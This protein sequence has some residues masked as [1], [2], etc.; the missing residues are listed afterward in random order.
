MKV[1]FLTRLFYPHVGGIEKHIEKVSEVLQSK[2]CEV[3]V[4][5]IKYDKSLPDN[6]DYKNIKIRRFRQPAIKF[7]GT[8]YTWIFLFRKRSL[9]EESDVVHIH[10]VFVWYWPFKLIYPNKKVYIT[11]HGRWGAYPI[12]YKDII[13]KRLGAKLSDGVI[14][15]G[16]Y[17]TKNYSINAD[18]ISYGATEVP[19]NKLIKDKKLAIYVGRM[20]EDIAL[21]KIFEVFDKLKSDYKIIFCGDGELK[22]KA[23]IYGEVKGFVDPKPYYKK[24]AYCFASG[25]LTILEALSNKCLVFTAYENPLQ[26]D[27]YSLTPFTKYIS[28]SGDPEKLLKEFRQIEKNPIRAKKMKNEGYEWVKEQTWEKMSDNYLTLWKE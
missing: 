28:V 2:G 16:R 14:A 26:K 5:T 22:K 21:D 3:R 13:Q 15:I 27:Y 8:V 25:Y 1:L 11:F 6:E 24:A 10:D 9:I 18:I 4:L 17:I 12:P 20:D 19:N 7:L 23:R